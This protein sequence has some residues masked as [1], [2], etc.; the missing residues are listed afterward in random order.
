M[1][2]IATTIAALL[3]PLRFCSAFS[4]NLT[5]AE[6]W[7]L[8]AVQPAERDYV[9]C[10]ICLNPYKQPIQLE[11]RHKFCQG[12]LLTAKDIWENDG[13]R[14]GETFPCPI[15][16]EPMASPKLDIDMDD[17]VKT[18]VMTTCECGWI[19]RGF[20]KLQSHLEGD[21]PHKEV[22]DLRRRL[23][24]ALE[25]ISLK[26]NRIGE[27]ETETVDLRDRLDNAIDDGD[28]EELDRTKEQLA[29]A[30]KTALEWQH[31]CTHLRQ[32][33]SDTL[34]ASRTEIEARDEKIEAQEDTIRR[35]SQRL[36]EQGRHHDRRLGGRPKSRSPRRNA[37][38]YNDRGRHR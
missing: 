9:M 13:D 24:A 23:K 31:Q 21:C 2:A 5:M 16:R 34:L 26:Q 15:C 36:R 8:D 29:T 19:G 3:Q 11:C 30:Q 7:S 27:L 18:L 38:E 25:H 35:L 6:D 32:V 4:R 33:I 28:G 22:R 37:R 17:F 12:C 10:S 14:S 1:N 20:V